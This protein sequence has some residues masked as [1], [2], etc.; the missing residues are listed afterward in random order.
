M[1]SSLIS[2]TC[3]CAVV[4][5]IVAPLLGC[6][7]GSAAEDAKARAHAALVHQ[8]AF[9][10]WLAEANYEAGLAAYEAKDYKAAFEDWHEVADTGDAEAELRLGKLSEEGLGVPQ[11]Y[12]EAHR[13]YNLAA[14]GGA[15]G[16][17]AARDALA[18]KMSKEQ[19]G[20][21]QRLAAAWRPPSRAS[22]AAVVGT[23]ALPETPSASASSP[24][25]AEAVVHF[26]AGLAAFKAGSLDAA[27]AELS[28]GLALSPDAV[29]LFLLGEAY[30]LSHQDE[31]ALKAYDDALALDP[32]STIAAK[33]R[34]SAALLAAGIEVKTAEGTAE[35]QRLLKLLGYYSGPANGKIGPKTTAAVE[36]FAKKQGIAADG[37]ITLALVGALKQAADAR[38]QQAQVDFRAGADAL[39]AGRS[40]QAIKALAAGLALKEDAGAEYALADAYR[41]KGD[42]AAALERYRRALAL[43]PKSPAAAKAL[44]AV[45]TLVASAEPQAGEA[46][47]AAETA[48][49]PQAP[50]PA[51]ETPPAAE[52][53][54]SQAKIDDIRRQA[55]LAG[56][57]ARAAQAEAFEAQLRAR[58]AATRAQHGGGP[59]LFA[60]SPANTPGDRYEGGIDENKRY[61]G[62]GVY[63]FASG[64]RMEGEFK[65]DGSA[66]AHRIY[67]W[68][69]G[70]H[71]EGE[72]RRGAGSERDG[73]GVYTTADGHRYEGQWVHDRMSGYMISTAPNGE[74]YE[75]EFR[76]DLAN[77]RGILLDSTGQPIKAGI[78]RDGKLEVSFAE[79]GAK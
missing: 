23:A 18:A 55:G 25:S 70:A 39:K 34:A 62:F 4:A 3:R 16:A 28:A 21:A 61:A 51:A 29:A 45:R 12:I 56:A 20:E 5:L 30:R 76:D 54:E 57:R 24:P 40:E 14:A 1:K 2:R 47:A 31:L 53:T 68:A 32:A 6:L 65:P 41:Q 79:I 60:G 7:G 11:N 36:S 35:A 73:Y 38:A 72:Y 44:E 26:K 43:D 17:A 50:A 58:D 49:L 63:Y 22:P 48:A 69:D 37:K 13:W 75:G 19:L 27:I 71:Y 46:S 42:N 64:D 67:H 10:D 66:P 77:G 52:G 33:A 78:W 8:Q 9:K 59:G 74:Q 15:P